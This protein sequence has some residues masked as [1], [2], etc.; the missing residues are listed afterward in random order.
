MFTHGGG[1]NAPYSALTLSS[2]Y[3]LSAL[4]FQPVSYNGNLLVSGNFGVGAINNSYTF[5]NNGTSYLNGAVVVDDVA[6]FNVN[7]SST[8]FLTSAGTNACMIKADGG[9]E[10]YI[11]G[12]NTW[13]MRFSG[14][15]VLM[16]NGGYLLNGE[17][18]RTPIFYDSNNTAYYGDFAST[19]RINTI[20]FDQFNSTAYNTPNQLVT[21]AD[22]NWTYGCYH[23]GSSTYYMQVKFYGTGDDTRGFRVFNTNGSSVVWRINGAGNSIASGNVT[24]YS[25]ERLKTNWRNMPE[26]FV[27]RLSKVKVGIYD[28]TD[29]SKITQVGVG[30]QSLQEVLP[31]AVIKAD[32]EMGT[33][34]V[35]YGGAALASSVELAKEVVDLRARVAM[36][37]S[38]ISKLIDV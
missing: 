35:N 11:G 31:E 10:L 29:G 32:D 38:L 24:A 7:G 23:D 3:T 27:S 21:S 28:R 20:T 26:N 17:S 36:L 19:S 4:T 12:N 2:N 22:T 37:E 14:A 13:Q 1:A 5:Y 25:D 18:I 9:D 34:S 16:D 8:I 33:L 30:A 15:N 6:T